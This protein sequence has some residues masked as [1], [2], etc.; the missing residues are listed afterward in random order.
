MAGEH[1]SLWLQLGD[2]GREWL[3]SLDDDQ[4]SLFEAINFAAPDENDWRIG[5]SERFRGRGL[6]V[7]HAVWHW[8]EEQAKRKEE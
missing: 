6:S 3:F 8:R 7:L 5:Q 1:D 4:L 2:Q